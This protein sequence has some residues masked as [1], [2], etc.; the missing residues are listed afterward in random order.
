MSLWWDPEEAS[1]GCLVSEDPAIKIL[2]SIV[3]E[4]FVVL[5]IRL[6]C[7]KQ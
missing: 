4:I 6:I 1:E 2:E 7:M 5:F 3:F